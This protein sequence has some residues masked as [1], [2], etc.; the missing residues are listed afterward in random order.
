MTAIQCVPSCS[1]VL[2]ESGSGTFHRLFVVVRNIRSRPFALMDFNCT[3]GGIRSESASPSD[4]LSN[5]GY[6]LSLSFR[7]RIASLNVFVFD[8]CL[9]FPRGLILTLC[10]S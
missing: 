2:S 8:L 3:H 9:R 7:V 5:P 4:R 6:R 1:V 10:R